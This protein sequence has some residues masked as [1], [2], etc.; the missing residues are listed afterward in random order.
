M[1]SCSFDTDICRTQDGNILI[2]T[3]YINVAF[4]LGLNAPEANRFLWRRRTHC[5]ALVTENY[6][7]T[8]QFEDP[9]TGMRVNHTRY[10]YGEHLAPL[11]TNYTYKISDQTPGAISR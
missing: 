3:G 7:D 6:T 8:I 5:A 10:C 1:P 11:S 2:D 9:D 4:N